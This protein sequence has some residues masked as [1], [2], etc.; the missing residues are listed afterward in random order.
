MPPA[1]PSTAVGGLGGK[2]IRDCGVFDL[3]VP[4]PQPAVTCTHVSETNNSDWT[5]LVTQLIRKIDA[6]SNPCAGVT[7][8]QIVDRADLDGDGTLDQIGLGGH[9]T[10]SYGSDVWTPATHPTLRVVGGC[11]LLTHPIE[12]ANGPWYGAVYGGAA[13]VDDQPGRDVIVGY[14]QGAH[15]AFYTML[16]FRDGRRR[17]RRGA[18]R[19]VGPLAIRVDVR[20]ARVRWPGGGTARSPVGTNLD[21]GADPASDEGEDHPWHGS[22]FRA[23][24]RCCPPSSRRSRR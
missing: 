2:I 21:A 15:S 14:T 23:A 13:E 11:R 4:I 22:E 5:V 8:Y 10:R 12:L 17:V 3:T 24:R 20:P 6:A 9:T 16:R 19:G 1:T 7:D 18:S